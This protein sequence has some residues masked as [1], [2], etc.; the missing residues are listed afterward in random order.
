MFLTGGDWEPSD[1][2]LYI[3]WFC[4]K[5]AGDWLVEVGF[6]DGEEA[7]V[8]LGS[9]SEYERLSGQD[10]ELTD[11]LPRVR[12]KQPRLFFTVNHPLVNMEEARNHK[13]DANLL[14]QA[15][16]KDKNSSTGWQRGFRQIF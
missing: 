7:A 4:A 11:Q 16:Q 8:S 2:V 12:H 13:L 15:G 14:Q 10:G 6:G 5:W 1:F 3:S 9:D